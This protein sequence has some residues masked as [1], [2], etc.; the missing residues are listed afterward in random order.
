M[1]IQPKN[2]LFVLFI[3]TTLVISIV[4]IA[5]SVRKLEA[6]EQAIMYDS[7]A[8]RTV[9]TND[10][11]LYVG[12]PLYKWIKYSAVYTPVA[13]NLSCLTQ[14][15]LPVGLEVTFQYVPKK[16]ALQDITMSFRDSDKFEKVVTDAATS[17]VLATC[18]RFAI[19]EF[20]SGRPIIQ[21][22]ID[23]TIKITLS[24]LRADALAAQLVNVAV[25]EAWNAATSNKQRAQQDIDFALN[26]R[27]QAVYKGNNNVTIARQ[28][29][30]ITNQTAQTEISII[31]NAA[32]EDAS[33][34]AKEYEKHGEVLLDMVKQY[35]LT[36]GGLYA[37]LA[38]S[39]VRGSKDVDLV[40]SGA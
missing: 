33:A 37:F 19:A 15:G 22:K 5:T 25:P 20:Q 24:E 6:N 29:A 12:P 21:A 18:S 16:E 7:V 4:L 27:A 17:A 40:L 2:V 38:N 31:L 9:S 13:M 30:L 3:L 39:L 32:R 23:E 26:E 36:F 35:N 1:A 28:D 11:G 14:D 34:L 8:K 10:Q